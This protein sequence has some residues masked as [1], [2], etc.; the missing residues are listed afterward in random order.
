MEPLESGHHS[1][2]Q[3]VHSGTPGI[4]APLGSNGCLH[5]RVKTYSYLQSVPERNVHKNEVSAFLGV[6]NSGHPLYIYTFMKLGQLLI[7]SVPQSGRNRAVVWLITS[8]IEFSFH[9]AP[10]SGRNLAEFQTKAKQI[11][12]KLTSQSPLRCS[13]ESEPLVFQLVPTLLTPS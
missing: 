3:S 4:R 2:P 8:R 12:R 5:F 1:D 11:F 6:R 9:S 7:H 13:I 10:Q